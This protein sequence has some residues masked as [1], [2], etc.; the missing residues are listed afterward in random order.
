MTAALDPGEN[1]TRFV[2]WAEA[3]GVEINGIAPARFVDRGVGIVAAHDIKVSP[4]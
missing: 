1:H 2:E 4:T 3:N